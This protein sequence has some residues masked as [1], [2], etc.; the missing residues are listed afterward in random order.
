MRQHGTQRL[1]GVGIYHAYQPCA[2][3]RSGAL[4][5]S[6][7]RRG[8]KTTLRI[9]AKGG[10]GRIEAGCQIRSI[11]DVKASH[12]LQI[13]DV[14]FLPEQ[15]DGP[16]VVH[17]DAADLARKLK[18]TDAGSGLCVPHCE[19]SARHGGRVLVSR[20]ADEGHQGG[21][22]EHLDEANHTAVLAVQQSSSFT[23]ENVETSAA[24]NGQAG[25]ILVKPQVQDLLLCPARFFHS[26]HGAWAA[27]PIAH[28][29]REQRYRRKRAFCVCQS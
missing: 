21:A 27:D 2:S 29:M 5:T 28:L 6:D 1:K 3:F 11:D 7:Q 24:A 16:P 22:E 10:E 26:V 12:C 9:A 18:L 17:F 13:K 23:A 20:A 14:D 15:H 19:L 8:E 4:R 25:A